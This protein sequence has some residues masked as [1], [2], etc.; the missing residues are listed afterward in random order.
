MTEILDIY[1]RIAPEISSFYEKQTHIKGIKKLS[2]Q[3]PP[4][5]RVLDLG[6]GSGRDVKTFTDF[7]F[8]CIGIEGSRGMVAQA[9]KRY[10]KEKYFVMDIRKLKFPDGYFE[11]V[12][13]WSVL[14]HLDRKGKKQSLNEV[15]RV[16]KKGGI[17]IQTVWKGRG[18]F[19][20]PQFHPRPHNLLSTPSWKK[21]YKETGFGDFSTTIF[22]GVG[23]DSLR[24]KAKKL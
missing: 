7:G 1:D 23:R 15:F 14:T 19:I 5:S 3:I 10:P 18:V 17:F 6:S 8:D 16:L 21:L 12:W 9:K 13:S 4:K 20:N 24:I 2:S 22:N 11:A